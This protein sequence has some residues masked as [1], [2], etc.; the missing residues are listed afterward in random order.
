MRD[1]VGNGASTSTVERKPMNLWNYEGAFALVQFTSDATRY[2][3][4][5]KLLQCEQEI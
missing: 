3:I 1:I 5:Q 4:F 2:A